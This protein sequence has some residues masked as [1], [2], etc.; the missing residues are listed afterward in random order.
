MKPRNKRER[1]VAELSSKL[2]LL[3]KQ[4]DWAK[5]H[6]FSH[7][8]FKCKDELWCS[9]CGHTWINTD[10][11]EL[12]I[13]LKIG[14][15]KVECPYCHNKLIVK[16]SRKQKSEEV[17]YMTVAEVC[18]DYQVLRHMYCHRFTRK[19]D[20]YLRYFFCEVVQEWIY[21]DGKRT[22]MARPM[23][24]GG[25]GWLYSEELSIKSEY[26]SGYYHSYGDLYALHGEIYPK[27]KLLPELRKYGLKCSFH[28]L[29]PSR[30][31]RSL[32][33]NTGDYE[34]C[35]K[36]KQYSMLQYLAKQ[37]N[38]SIRYKPSFNICNRN[39]YKIRDASM[40]IDYIDLLSYFG[41]DLRN[42]HYVCPRN[43]NREHD[44][45]MNKKNKIETQL[46]E[47]RS[48]EAA[49]RAAIEK[50]EDTLSFYREKM[51]FFGIEIKDGDITIHPLESITQFYLEGRE[52]HHCVFSN[53]YYRK[54][55][56]LILSAKDPQGKRL[57]TIEI[58]LKTFEIVQSRAVCNK[59]SEYH[60][61]ILEIVRKNI[62]L[63]RKRIAS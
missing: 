12:G 16:V 58:N 43:L 54:S 60:D 50:K 4:Y 37:G 55:D 9:D 41:K 47:Q 40:W 2:P 19:I 57:E 13:I 8:A 33:S 52:M 42:A 38:H 24:M 36:T 44:S 31:V 27:L 45:L 18:G 35:L 14:K 7:E 10:N 34:L 5:T 15:D 62:G 22:I 1:E 30:M 49:V 56:C 28:G 32:L 53:R 39:K 46:R 17:N 3:T 63:I 48:R 11:S 29:T 51:K 59:T 26:G 21:K 20:A 6:V 23:N 25:N 61:R